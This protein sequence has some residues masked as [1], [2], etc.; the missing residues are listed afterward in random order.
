MAS[1]KERWNIKSNWQVFVILVVFAV[2]GS[3]S[4]LLSKPVLE[5]FGIVK[6]DVSNWLYYPLYLILIFPIYQVLLVSFGFIFGQF[7]FFWAFEKKMLKSMGL[8][9]LFPNKKNPE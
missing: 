6:G 3:S 4:A 5:L 2:T 1:F 8:G 9:F 7:T